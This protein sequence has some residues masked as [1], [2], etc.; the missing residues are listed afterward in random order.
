MLKLC[1][2]IRSLCLNRNI[3]YARINVLLAAYNTTSKTYFEKKTKNEKKRKKKKTFSPGSYYQP[4]LNTT[5]KSNCS[6][7]EE[8]FCAF[9][10]ARTEK[11]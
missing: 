7:G 2:L 10:S 6:V 9:F 5:G 4:G 1:D 11:V 8:F 3:L